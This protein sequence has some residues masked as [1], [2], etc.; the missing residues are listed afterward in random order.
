MYFQCTGCSRLRTHQRLRTLVVTPV[1]ASCGLSNG[2]VTIGAVTGGT[3]PYTYSFNG[4]AYGAA[5][6]LHMNLAAGT[7]TISVKDANGCIFNAPDAV[8]GVI[9]LQLQR[10]WCTPVDASCGLS[11][12]SV[13]ISAVTGGTAPYTYSFNGGALRCSNKLYEILLL[14]HT[15]SQ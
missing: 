6:K 9:L 8:I 13:T 15:R 11:N 14:V 1:D 10:S 5:Y 2:S 7:Y 12:G 3:A 4:G